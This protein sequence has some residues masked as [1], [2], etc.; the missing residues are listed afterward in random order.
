MQGC[1]DLAHS[2]IIR[3]VSGPPEC[4]DRRR[5]AQ[6]NK[7]I[8][9]LIIVTKFVNEF[10]YVYWLSLS[11]DNVQ[12]AGQ[13]IIAQ[14]FPRCTVGHCPVNVISLIFGKVIKLRPYSEDYSR[15][16]KI[17][18]VHPCVISCC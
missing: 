1:D 9:S 8:D 6:C 7:Q 10:N 3:V 15:F 12:K 11:A 13:I 17:V 5:D 18:S 14:Y 2:I 4:A 16:C